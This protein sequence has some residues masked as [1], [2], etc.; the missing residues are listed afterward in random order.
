M[1]RS[2]G[3]RTV[4][5]L[6]HLKKKMGHECDGRQVAARARVDQGSVRDGSQRVAEAW[7]LIGKHL[8]LRLDN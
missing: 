5:V 8:R 2:L 3:P 1:W 7:W 6:R 4:R